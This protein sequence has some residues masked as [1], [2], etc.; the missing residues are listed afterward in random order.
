MSWLRA[1]ALE[2]IASRREAEE[3]TATSIADLCGAAGIELPGIRADADD[4]QRARRV[5]W[6]LGRCFPA[7]NTLEIEDLTIERLERPVE[8]SN[9]SAFTGK[10]YR[11]SRR[12][13]D[14]RR[15]HTAVEKRYVSIGVKE[16]YA[17][18]RADPETRG[19]VAP[20]LSH[21][22][23]DPARPGPTDLLSKA[24]YVRYQSVYA[25]HDGQPS[26]KHAAAWRAALTD[27]EVRS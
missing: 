5:G 2:V 6:L 26:E 10:A 22:A 21:P 7:D 23:L 20:P 24:Q 8:R 4:A 16:V 9:G 15:L 3:L 12:L 11:F 14:P 1:L 19:T 18:L 25:A 27:G 13:V 17:G